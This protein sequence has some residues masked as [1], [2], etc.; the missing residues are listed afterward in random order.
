MSMGSFLRNQDSPY[1]NRYYE[2]MPRQQ[3]DA[4][5]LHRIKAVLEH[6]YAHTPFYRRKL[7]EAGVHLGS[8][9]TLEDFKRK[10]PLL[11]KDEFIQLQ[12]QRPNYG[13][14]LAVAADFVA[15]HCE[16][17]G[18]TG[19]PLRIPYTGYDTE[20]YGEAWAY[21]LWALGVRPRDVCYFA[22]NWGPFAGF[23]SAYWGVRRLG[24]TVIPGGGQTSEGHIRMIQRLKPTVLLCTPTYALH[25]A[26]VARRMGVE[27]SSLS[28]QYTYHA[29]EPGPCAIPA[30]RR[31]I[32]ESW[33]SISGELLGLAEVHAMAPS[34]PL[35]EGV[36]VD[37]TGCF[38]WSRDPESGA[39]VPEGAIGENIVTTYVNNAQPL[40]NYRTHDLVERHNQCACGR[41]WAYFKGS[42]LGRTDFMVTIRGT[43][44]YQSAVENV[45]G[46]V[47][48]LSSHYELVLTRVS[49]MDR[50]CVRAE[51]ASEVPAERYSEL[52][53]ST[54]QRI[55]E[56]MKVRLEVEL[57]PPDTLPR[58]ELKTRRIIDQRP[59][60]VRRALDRQ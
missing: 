50:M 15:H 57:V 26:E 60:E 6:T 18:T 47:E 53:R 3:L 31:Q 16:T 7:D 36:H 48:G 42:L 40:I 52:A 21:G 39:E 8:I 33:G 5:H 30:M 58:Y 13:D 22:F 54:D 55:R 10:V 37:E 45:L 41:T 46:Q 35:G 20:R 14:T 4:L 32:N 24:A 38:S 49:G 27:P 43:N 1:W 51:P 19:I 17:S 9:R 34:C 25:L 23:W 2:T 12:D 44:V 56:A 11:D 29:G 28:I 59:K